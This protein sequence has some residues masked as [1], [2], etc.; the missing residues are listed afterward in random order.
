MAKLNNQD[1]EN[2]ASKVAA[3]DTDQQTKTSSDA[4]PRKEGWRETIESV[5]IAFILAFLFRTFEAEAF[6]IPTGS[7]APTLYGRHKEITCPEC[8]FVYAV[9]ASSELDQNTSLLKRPVLS[10]AVCPNCRFLTRIDKV[11]GAEDE[12]TPVFKGDRILV[13]KF[14]FEFGDPQRWDIVVF[15]FPEHPQTNYIK[16]LIGLPGETLR[17]QQGDVYARKGQNTPL[18]ILRKDNP[19]KQREV[20]I[21]VYDDAF[22]ERRLHKIGWPERWAAVAKDGAP[23]HI[24]G[25]SDDNAGWKHDTAAR[26]FRL[27]PGKGKNK[28]RRWIR[29]RHF[30]PRRSD[31]DAVANGRREE[32]DARSRLQL[33]AD[34]CGY[35]ATDGNPDMERGQYWVGDLMLS[36]RVAIDQVVPKA[37]LLFELNE[38]WRW[39]RCRIDVAT[40][41]AT[42]SHTDS[43]SRDEKDEIVLATAET[44]V[45]GKGHYDIRFSNVDD[46]LCLWVDDDLVEFGSQAA[47]K[48][49][50]GFNS[51]QEPTDSD[52]APVGIAARG[53]GIT[54]SRLLLERDIY[55]RSELLHPYS[56]YIND[57]YSGGSTINEYDS[58]TN[59]REFELLLTDPTAWFQEYERGLS[60]RKTGADSDEYADVSFEFELGPDEFFMMGDNSPSSK[61][62]RLWANTRRAEHRHAVPRSALVGKAFFIYWPHG[63]PFLNDGLGYPTGSD[64]IWNN[65]FLAWFFYHREFDPEK[66]GQNDKIPTKLS[67][68]PKFRVPFYPNISRMRRLR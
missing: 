19:D 52:M 26:S 37:E 50:G 44:S 58:Q 38:G 17:I 33:I 11:S 29:Y 30:L 2:A 66:Q 67:D 41:K 57:D 51:L 18:R 54:V 49:H 32:L 3:T 6:V 16:R 22:P 28:A 60:A 61:D 56:H 62:S 21:L 31:W 45:T 27:T 35:N 12:W 10:E 42:L 46:R 25:W 40:G 15:K 1:D 24:T 9:G 36:C 55:Y 53:L 13:N 65:R 34:F 14:P 8:K 63:V 20:R 5:V 48:P 47:Y 23:G 39:Y 4:P 7:M 43:L 68:Y 64:S 59:G